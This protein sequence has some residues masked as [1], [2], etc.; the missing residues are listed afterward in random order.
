MFPFNST[1]PVTLQGQATPEIMP[2]IGPVPAAVV[3][4]L[5]AEVVDELTG[6]LG[7]VVI[8]EEVVD[9][10]SPAHSVVLDASGEKGIVVMGDASANRSRDARRKAGD[11]SDDSSVWS[12]EVKEDDGLA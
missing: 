7:D 11:A 10:E 2:P 3:D 5:G 1:V 8:A 12:W 6:V 4:V 9:D